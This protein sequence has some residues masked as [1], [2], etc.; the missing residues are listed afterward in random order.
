MPLSGEKN[1]VSNFSQSPLL[2]YLSNL[3]VMRTGMKARNE[4]KFGPDRIII[5]LANFVCVGVYC[6]HVRLSMT[7]WFFLKTLKRQ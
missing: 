2:R 3:Q 6:F 1:A 5:P 7:F 4:F